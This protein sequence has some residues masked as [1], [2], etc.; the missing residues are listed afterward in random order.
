M[1][2]TPGRADQGA[3]KSTTPWSTPVYFCGMLLFH[4]SR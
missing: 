3:V 2:G 4:V 1:P